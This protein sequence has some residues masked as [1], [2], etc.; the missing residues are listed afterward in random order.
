[1][2]S[3]ETEGGHLEVVLHGLCSGVIGQD[4]AG[5]KAL[6]RFQDVS[7]NE[8]LQERREGMSVFQKV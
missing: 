4:W 7:F 3:W 1:M 6:V 2:G 5:E 8:T